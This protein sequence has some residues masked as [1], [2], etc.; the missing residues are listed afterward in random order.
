M[1]V[2]EKVIF[3]S[4]PLSVSDFK[5]RTHYL[6]NPRRIRSPS[7]PPRIQRREDSI[8]VRTPNTFKEREKQRNRGRRRRIIPFRPSPG[9][10]KEL[11]Y[12]SPR[13]PM[14]KNVIMPMP[15]RLQHKK[16]NSTVY[17]TSGFHTRAPCPSPPLNRSFKKARTCRPFKTMGQ[18]SV[19][20]QYA[21]RRCSPP[22]TS[23]SPVHP[24]VF[25]NAET[26]RAGQINRNLLKPMPIHSKGFEGD[27][28]KSPRKRF[29]CLKL[30][31][32]VHEFKE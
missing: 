2:D 26:S 3:A 22:P 27:K 31:T 25:V 19:S 13:C 28:L 4:D 21:H 9:T 18:S 6:R 12:S 16:G 15:M 23:A 32:G 24:C 8:P 20:F 10:Y 30:S 5:M 7:T 11:T 1:D 29:G 17:Q 14:K